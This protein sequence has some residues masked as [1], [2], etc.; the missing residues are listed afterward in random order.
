MSDEKFVSVFSRVT[1]PIVSLIVVLML[2]YFGGIYVLITS[3]P[4]AYASLYRAVSL[5]GGFVVG[6]ILFVYLQYSLLTYRD[7]TKGERG[8]LLGLELLFRTFEVLVITLILATF[9]WGIPAL[10]GT[11][12]TEPQPNTTVAD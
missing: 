11:L 5:M 4:E 9:V 10:L 6:I 1:I 8:E 3:H 2:A 7:Y 12:I